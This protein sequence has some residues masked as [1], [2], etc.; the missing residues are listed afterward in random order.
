MIEKILATIENKLPL[1]N[2]CFGTQAMPVLHY[3][4]IKTCFVSVLDPKLQCK[5]TNK[6]NDINYC[7]FPNDK[8]QTRGYN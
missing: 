6:V 4:D 7:N 2:I 5:Y 1:C 3:K 8:D